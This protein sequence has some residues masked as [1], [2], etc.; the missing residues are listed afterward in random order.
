MFRTKRHIVFLA[1]IIGLLLKDALS[2]AAVSEEDRIKAL[3]LYNFLLFVDWPE[4]AIGEDN[5]LRVAVIGDDALFELFEPM[6]QK[7]IKGRKLVVER[8]DAVE[9]LSLPCHVLFVGRSQRDIAPHILDKI[10]DRPV[11]TVSDMKGFTQ[12]GGMV[13]FKHLVCKEHTASHQKRF[14]INL[15]A[16]E[17]AGL[18]I[19]SRLL[20]LSDI[21]DLP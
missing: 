21:V 7:P 5:T 2:I 19:R 3:Y 10:R 17:H 11:L 9:D 20:R 4:D 12:M 15:S 6:A 13:Y 8:F 16:V 18:K 1:V 14:E